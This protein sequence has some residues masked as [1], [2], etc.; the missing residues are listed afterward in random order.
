MDESLMVESESGMEDKDDDDDDEQ[1]DAEEY[2]PMYDNRIQA[3]KY[4]S[5]M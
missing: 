1:L 2:V 4:N 5:D 3:N